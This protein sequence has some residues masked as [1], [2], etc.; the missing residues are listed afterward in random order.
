MRLRTHILSRRT[1]LALAASVALTTGCDFSFLDGAE[2]SDP[3][4]EPASPGPSP[5]VEL[6]W[7][8]TV[9]LAETGAALAV[10]ASDGTT[11]LISVPFDGSS[12]APVLTREEL[13]V[14]LTELASRLAS[15][16]LPSD[17]A[18]PAF[19]SENYAAVLLVYHAARLHARALVGARYVEVLEAYME[20]GRKLPLMEIGEDPITDAVVQAVE[21]GLEDPERMERQY[22]DARR[23]VDQAAAYKALQTLIMATMVRGGPKDLDGDDP[24]DTWPWEVYGEEIDANGAGLEIGSKLARVQALR[25]TTGFLGTTNL[26]DDEM[27]FGGI[28][29]LVVP[30]GAEQYGVQYFRRFKQGSMFDNDP[31]QRSYPQAKPVND[32]PWYHHI[33]TRG[34]SRASYYLQGAWSEEDF[35][36]PKK[37]RKRL[38]KIESVL[39]KLLEAGIK[40]AAGNVAGVAQDLATAIGPVLGLKTDELAE[41]L[42]DQIKDS[43]GDISETVTVFVLEK[44]AELLADDPVRPAAKFKCKIRDIDTAPKYLCYDQ[45]QAYS[46]TYLNDG[47]NYRPKGEVFTFEQMG[48]ED[49][50]DVGDRSEANYIFTYEFILRDEVSPWPTAGIAGDRAKLGGAHQALFDP[51]VKLTIP[52]D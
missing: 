1:M 10:T 43:S 36:T 38:G 16:M 42:E 49:K 34:Q 26:E 33:P 2:P 22:D 5:V 12:G 51:S 17:G 40:A 9:R 32:Y 25:L 15:P 11:Q 3:P 14:S 30:E 45:A 20:R 52:N 6:A 47:R 37:W 48:W 50:A 27:L 44:V 13:S 24:R 23:A 41:D 35:G 39:T 19:E 46:R 28:S 4:Q 8:G 29:H 7:G 31:E 21:D 18:A